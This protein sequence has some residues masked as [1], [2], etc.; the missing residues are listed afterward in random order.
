MNAGISN[1]YKKKTFINPRK[2]FMEG[3]LQEV[4]LLQ[5]NEEIPQDL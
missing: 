1:Q 5:K 2:E 3:V 4:G